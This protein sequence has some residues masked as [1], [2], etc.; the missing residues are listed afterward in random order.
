MLYY[1]P[2]PVD[3]R[4][5]L[6]PCI[7]IVLRTWILT[8][9]QVPYKLHL[10]PPPRICSSHTHILTLYTCAHVHMYTYVHI[11]VHIISTSSLCVY[12]VLLGNWEET[13]QEWLAQVASSA[14]MT[15]LSPTHSTPSPRKTPRKRTVVNKAPPSIA[16]H[17][18]TSTTHVPPTTAVPVKK[19]GH[20]K[21]VNR[22]VQKK[23]SFRKQRKYYNDLNKCQV[24]P[25]IKA[26]HVQWVLY[27][28]NTM[29]MY[30]TITNSMWW[31]GNG[32]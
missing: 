17:G 11:C 13:R 30:M 28:Y 23:D 16:S 14:D 32:C 18:H 3:D 24:C 29:Y 7:V 12:C 6:H 22:H 21:T 31:I 27:M 26:F 2:S 15:K 19:S 1:V 5:V 10:P 20:D 8:G 9:H 4:P 25:V